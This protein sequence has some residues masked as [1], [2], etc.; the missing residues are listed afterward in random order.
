MES[1]FVGLFADIKVV[2]AESQHSKDQ[3]GDLSCG[4]K[5][6]DGT[7]LV[8][9]DSAKRGPERGLGALQGKR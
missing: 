8:A 2:L 3:R 4:G 7:A 5:D 6:S 9:S 1:R